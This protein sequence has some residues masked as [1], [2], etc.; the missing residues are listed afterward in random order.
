MQVPFEVNFG[1]AGVGYAFLSEDG[2][3]SKFL[4]QSA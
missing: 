1:D 3:T 2:T 4:W